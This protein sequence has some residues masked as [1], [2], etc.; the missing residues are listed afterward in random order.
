MKKVPLGVTIGLMALAAAAAV[1]L[2]YH[3][4]IGQINAKIQNI[5]ERQA[6]FSQLG[7]IDVLARSNHY[8]TLDE[9]VLARA[10]AEGYVEGLQDENARFF[11]AAECK[12]YAD[13][14]G[15]SGTGAGLEVVRDSDG[16]LRVVQVHQDSPAEAAGVLPGD[17]IVTMDGDTVAALDAVQAE[18]RL[19][20]EEGTALELEIL[21]R[22]EDLSTDAQTHTL[23]VTFARFTS[24]TVEVSV[25][26]SGVGYIRICRMRP[27]TSAEF[28]EA[29]NSLQGQN[30]TGLVLDLRDCGGTAVT[31]AAEIADQ[32]LGIAD[33][34]R[35]LDAQGYMTV[36]Y[37]S[38][39]GSAELDVCALV[40]SQ[41][42]GAAEV[43]VAA[44]QDAGCP[45]VGETTC[46][47]ADKT[48]LYQLSDGSALLLTAGRYARANASAIT[49]AGVVPTQVAE[50]T[51][52]QVLAH[53]QRRLSP[54]ADAQVQAAVGQISA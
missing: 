35:C 41:T 49:G 12:A 19:Y 2:T 46:G 36:E 42:Q 27:G 37:T 31:A 29:L 20:G 7:E 51:A 43:L 53:R 32:L 40:N 4:A 39:A 15:D 14:N 33:T 47:H 18:N 16:T 38:G 1:S 26:E 52:E 22:G 45:V 30:V 28:T 48:Q 17:V 23:H 50:L 24:R 25:L 54:D 8:D 5:N 44:L 21:R 6:M 11:D 3:V 10:L 9:N 34:V 13:A